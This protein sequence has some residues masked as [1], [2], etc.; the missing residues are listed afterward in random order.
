MPP[1]AQPFSIAKG[2]RICRFGTP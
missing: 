2:E 1:L